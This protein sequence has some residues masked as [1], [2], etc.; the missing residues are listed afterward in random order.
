MITALSLTVPVYALDLEDQI[1]TG[2]LIDSL[3]EGVDSIFEDYKP[4]Q[5][6]DEDI[7]DRMLSR[8][9][10][11]LRETAAPVTKTAGVFITVCLFI[12]LADT[13][14][15]GDAAPRFILFAGVAAIGTTALSDLDS[16][17]QMGIDSLH[18]VADYAK[19]LLP[20]LSSA[21]ALTGTVGSAAAKYAATSLFMSVFLDIADQVVVPC[22]C[23]YAAL[24][25]A[26]AAVGNN[27]LKT[28]KK[29]LKNISTILLTCICMAFT[30]YL[31]LTGVVTEAADAVAARAAK[32][33]ISGALPVVGGVLADAA[34]TLAAAAGALRGSI[35]IFGLLA[36]CGMCLTP[37]AALGMRY[38]AY[39]LSAAFCSCISDKRLTVLVEDL[40]SCFG[41]VLALNGAGALMLFISVYSLIRTV[42]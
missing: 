13:L 37:F 24:A 38:A 27:T 31:G 21:A 9:G 23:A 25:V 36:V 29:L 7:L 6:P 34:G 10:E 12:S 32:T 41:I 4:T 22:V 20:V 14:K 17:L 30:A 35:G 40:G 3:P 1:D 11:A 16:Y 15:L 26:D 19:Q 5:L 18:T 8:A 39:K 33:A 2:S 28:A 42:M